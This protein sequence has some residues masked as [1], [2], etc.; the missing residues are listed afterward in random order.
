MTVSLCFNEKNPSIIKSPQSKNTPLFATQIATFQSPS[1][2]LLK[3]R[4]NGPLF[5]ASP[6][7]QIPSQD[8]FLSYREIRSCLDAIRRLQSAPLNKK[9]QTAL[10]LYSQIKEPISKYLSEQSRSTEE[11]LLATHA[12]ACVA[13]GSLFLDEAIEYV[14]THGWLCSEVMEL[15]SLYN[16][17][18]SSSKSGNRELYDPLEVS[19][20]IAIFTNSVSGDR[21]PRAEA[22]LA[23]SDHISC[24]LL[25]KTQNKEISSPLFTPFLK[26]N[27][28]RIQALITL[29]EESE[30][31]PKEVQN[32]YRKTQSAILALYKNRIQ[33]ISRM[34][35]AGIAPS[36]NLSPLKIVKE[37][38]EKT[39]DQINSQENPPSLQGL[40]SIASF[41][42]QE[43]HS[44]HEQ[45]LV[46]SPTLEDP[47]SPSDREH[48]SQAFALPHEREI[49]SLCNHIQNHY[50][51]K[52]LRANQI[53]QGEYL[54]LKHLLNLCVTQEELLFPRETIDF[55][56]I[57][58]VC[59]F[60]T[61]CT[62]NRLKDLSK[63]DEKIFTH[64]QDDTDLSRTSPI[65]KT[66]T[67]KSIDE[68]DFI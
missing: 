28:I 67:S 9:N 2:N 22:I 12:G 6:T 1:K 42:K 19:Q 36:E 10:N 52:T 25:S 38:L 23:I 8:P 33:E 65:T 55:E 24:L 4:L 48:K 30:K 5:F 40:L 20:K 16:I 32:L 13:I 50:E 37:I 45:E 60:I 11:A 17:V 66:A 49:F 21:S 29:Y 47:S 35:L 62:P 68:G 31:L 18:L 57:H 7:Q 34:A 63:E 46:F 59:H 3:M 41:L 54:L 58:T 14:S 43:L 64:P 51:Q 39:L 53:A 61:K 56:D 26:E 27:E 15:V 44:A